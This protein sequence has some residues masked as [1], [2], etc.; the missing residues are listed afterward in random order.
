MRIKHA[1]EIVKYLQL[2]LE[3]YK[4]VYDMFGPSKRI[5]IELNEE[6]KEEESGNLIRN[7]NIEQFKGLI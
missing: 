5:A 3:N 1:N 7:L 4:N 2:E 6:E